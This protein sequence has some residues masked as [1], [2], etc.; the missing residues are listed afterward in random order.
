ML[1]H[2][3]SKGTMKCTLLALGGVARNEA[4]SVDFESSWKIP[5][6]EFSMGERFQFTLQIKKESSENSFTGVTKWEQ[7][8]ELRF[9]VFLPGVPRAAFSGFYPFS[10]PL[11]PSNP[12]TGEYSVKNERMAIVKGTDGAVGWMKIEL[13]FKLLS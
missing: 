3:S 6:I 12:K 8:G 11:F 7:T 4:G 10:L 13:Q 9:F 2:L 5:D 1:F